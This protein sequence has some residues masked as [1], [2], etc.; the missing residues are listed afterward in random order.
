MGKVK[1]L[2]QQPDGDDEDHAEKKPGRR[3]NTDPRPVE[4]HQL[5]TEDLGKVNQNVTETHKMEKQ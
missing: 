5:T 2:F 4:R 1:T 3:N